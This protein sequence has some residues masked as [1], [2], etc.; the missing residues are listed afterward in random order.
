M[1]DLTTDERIARVIADAALAK[2]LRDI[3]A[4][5]GIGGV[6]AEIDVDVRNKI[7][8]KWR[9]WI[10]LAIKYEGFIP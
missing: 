5:A 1:S 6:W 3:R 9:T 2:I 4:R 7:I 8:D 10:M